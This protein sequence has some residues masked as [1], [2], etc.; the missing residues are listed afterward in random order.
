MSI[1]Y[2]NKYTFASKS[3]CCSDNST[4]ITYYLRLGIKVICQCFNPKGYKLSGTT[5]ILLKRH[6]QAKIIKNQSFYFSFL[7]CPYDV[8]NVARLPKAPF[9]SYSCISFFGHLVVIYRLT[10]KRATQNLSEGVSQ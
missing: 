3:F 1:N 6:N 10:G 9:I 2:P 5:S 4:I 8:G 7:I